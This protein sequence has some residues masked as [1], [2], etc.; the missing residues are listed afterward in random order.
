MIVT[1]RSK[2]VR[3]TSNTVLLECEDLDLWGCD[4]RGISSISES[5]TTRGSK[6]RTIENSIKRDVTG[7]YRVWKITYDV[8]DI[9]RYKKILEF[10]KRQCTQLACM[11][12]CITNKCGDDCCNC[13]NVDATGE[14]EVVIDIDSFDYIDNGTYIESFTITFE[15]SNSCNCSSCN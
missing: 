11:T 5:W 4:V 13:N 7:Q 6:H 14:V 2:E 15:E 12:I 1:L 8:L 9:G 10:Y 3:D